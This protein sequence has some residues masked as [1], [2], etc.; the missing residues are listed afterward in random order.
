MKQRGRDVKWIMKRALEGI[1]PPEILAR[2][3]VGFPT[4]V[5]PMFRGPLADYVCDTLL[6]SRCTSRGYFNPASIRALV[7]AHRSG[8]RDVHDA[9]WRLIVL[10]EW[11]RQFPD[12]LHQEPER[13]RP[14]VA[15]VAGR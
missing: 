15:A 9:L 4:P 13:E 1:V 5:G 8:S 2:K 12:R 3:K 10:E 14:R 6:S 7:D 11:H